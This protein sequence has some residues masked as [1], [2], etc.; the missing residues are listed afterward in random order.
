V[1]ESKKTTKIPLKKPVTV[2]LLYW[3]VDTSVDGNVVFKPDIYKRDPAIIA[4][5]DSPF[6]FR[7]SQIIAD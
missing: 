6:R 3:T 5:L 1:V 4:A 2:L 7:S